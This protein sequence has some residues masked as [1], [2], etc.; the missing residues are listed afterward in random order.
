MTEQRPL[1]ILHCFR[2]PV[3]GIFRHVRDLAVEHSKAGH[4]VGILCD[5]ST[6]GE[7]EDR[8]FDD[9]RPFLAMGLTR[10][11]MRRHVSLSDLGMLW[12]TYKNIKSLRPDVLHGHGAKGGVLARLA[13]SA[14]RVNR[15][16]V[17]RLYTAHGGSLHYS[18]RSLLGQF[19]LRMERL[20]EYFTDALVFICEYERDAYTK[21]VGRPRTE[22]RLIY[23]GIGERD[24]ELI[25]TRS[26][27]V[28]YLYVGMLRDLKGPDLFVEAFAKAE[29]ILGRPLSA[30]MVGDGPDRDR[31]RDMMIE[32]GLGKRI[33][34]LPAMRVQQAFAM[35]QNLVVPS[36][37]EAMPYIVLEGLGAGK[38]IIATRVG[39][40]PE[41]LG[42]ESPAL[43]NPDDSDDLARAMADAIRIPGW[44]DAAM[45]ATEQV[46]SVF[47]ASVMANDVLKLYQDLLE[48]RS[49]QALG[50]AS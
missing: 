32:R 19:V 29:R 43:V 6:G 20:Q 5:S 48:P 8:L 42:R 2:S 28:H 47:S 41:A 23:N 44:H 45:P 21:K 38:T 35:S 9:I 11:P 7:H 26:D 10:M 1:R 22:T 50:A 37:A 17:A 14:L 27:A 40:I 49:K 4:E 12:D 16:R 36:R 3:G 24:F 18:R 31:Y 39:G 33:S 34:M 13:G 30:V 15:Y 46:K 25:P